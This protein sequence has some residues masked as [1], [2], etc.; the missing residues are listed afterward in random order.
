MVQKIS[1]ASI[2]NFHQ[3]VEVFLGKWE[4]KRSI[5]L[6]LELYDHLKIQSRET[7]QHFSSRFNQVYNSMPA[8][9]RP[10]PGLDLL[11]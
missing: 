1:A 6:I 2:S 8:D 9:I 3:F 5:F 10:P 4:I 7:V 11:H